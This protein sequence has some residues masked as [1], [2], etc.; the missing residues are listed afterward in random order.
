MITVA[1]EEFSQVVDEIDAMSNFG[2][3]DFQKLVLLPLSTHS[4]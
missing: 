3:D 2:N 4:A 1:D